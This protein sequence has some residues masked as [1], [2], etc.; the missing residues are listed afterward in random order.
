MSENYKLEIMINK[1]LKVIRLN[2][3]NYTYA[4]LKDIE[5]RED[6]TIYQKWSYPNGYYRTAE[7]AIESALKNEIKDKADK[8][9]TSINNYLEFMQKE[10]IDMRKLLIK[11]VTND[12]N[13]K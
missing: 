4:I 8:R 2:P 7:D 5:K 1:K 6:K 3:L 12:N 13:K 10:I 11:E 9:F